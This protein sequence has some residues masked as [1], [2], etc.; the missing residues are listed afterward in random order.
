MFAKIQDW[1][2]YYNLY[3]E[4]NLSLFYT[5]VGFIEP[6]DKWQSNICFNIIHNKQAA[7]MMCEVDYNVKAYLGQQRHTHGLHWLY[8]KAH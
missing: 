5:L 6:H 8:C 4:N 7:D 1:L 2:T 3:L